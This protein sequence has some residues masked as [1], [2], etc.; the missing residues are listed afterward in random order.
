[1]DATNVDGLLYRIVLESFEFNLFRGSTPRPSICRELPQPDL[2]GTWLWWTHFRREPWIT[3]W[4][5]YEGKRCT[6]NDFERCRQGRCGLHQAK[7][8]D[9]PTWS[10]G[11]DRQIVGG[12]CNEQW[13]VLFAGGV[14]C[15]AGRD[16]AKREWICG[17]VLFEMDGAF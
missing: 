10:C 7:R 5:E 13:D 12:A 14:L 4:K 16:D 11:W 17:S 15:I 1:M 6:T 3:E 8:S 9:V 2:K